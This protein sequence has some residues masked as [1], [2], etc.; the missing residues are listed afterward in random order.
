MYAVPCITQLHLFRQ[1]LSFNLGWATSPIGLLPWEQQGMEKDEP[2]ESPWNTEGL[3]GS[4]TCTRILF[5]L[6]IFRL[7]MDFIFFNSQR[8]QKEWKL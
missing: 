1:E 7:H 5:R 8:Q 2:W 6:H 4:G 3:H